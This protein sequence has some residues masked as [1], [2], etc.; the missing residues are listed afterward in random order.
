MIHRDSNLIRRI[1][2]DGPRGDEW[3]AGARIGERVV[4]GGHAFGPDGI[5]GCCLLLKKEATP[6]ASG[7]DEYRASGLSPQPPQ[8]SPP[9]SDLALARVGRAGEQWIR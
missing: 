5:R 6:S 7:A 1:W 3:R 9:L 4:R 2:I 8:G